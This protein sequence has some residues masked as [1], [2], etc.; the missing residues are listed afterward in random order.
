M[1][2]DF[3]KEEEDSEESF[4]DLLEEYDDRM[5]K[6]LEIGDKLRGKIISIGRES[7]F[8]GVDWKHSGKTRSN[9]VKGLTWDWNTDRRHLD[10]NYVGGLDLCCGSSGHETF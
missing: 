9:D 10:D 8:I 6:D 3:M 5:N 2:E 4:A 1:S 7:V